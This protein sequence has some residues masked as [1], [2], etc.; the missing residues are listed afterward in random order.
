M[1]L[2]WRHDTQHNKIPDNGNQHNET[3]HTRPIC[4]TQ[5]INDTPK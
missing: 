4:D 5:S 2:I 3:Q 1:V